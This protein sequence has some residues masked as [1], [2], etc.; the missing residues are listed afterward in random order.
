MLSLKPNTE[1]ADRLANVL[2]ARLPD[3]PTRIVLL[4]CIYNLMDAFADELDQDHTELANACL[5]KAGAA[6]LMEGEN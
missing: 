3:P 5:V 4:G 2:A 6:V 1:L